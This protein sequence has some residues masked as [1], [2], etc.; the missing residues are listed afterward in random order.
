MVHGNG[1]WGA[2]ADPYEAVAKSGVTRKA[3]QG[4]TGSVRVSYMQYY[5]A[6][7]PRLPSKDFALVA[8]GLLVLELSV[9]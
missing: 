7:F 8:S 5:V 1:A 9:L 3:R 2:Q 6:G 4:S